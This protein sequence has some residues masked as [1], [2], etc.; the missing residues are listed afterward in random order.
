[1][2]R[3]RHKVN[4]ST[5]TW[6]LRL[7]REVSGTY[8]EE[9]SHH[10]KH[11]LTHPGRRRTRVI[12][13]S[14]GLT[15]VLAGA[16]V[17]F[18]LPSWANA[19][20]A[21]RPLAS[22][23][24][25]DTSTPT[26]TDTP[27]A[28]PTPTD[29]PT[30][31][32]TPTGTPSPV[33]LVLRPDSLTVFGGDHGGTMKPYTVDVLANDVDPAGGHLYL[34]GVTQPPHGHAAIVNNKIVVNVS[35]GTGTFVLKYSVASTS[36][37][38]GTSKLTLRI[39]PAPIRIHLGLEQKN[40]VRGVGTMMTLRFS[41]PVK[42]RAAVQAALHLYSTKSF[43]EGAWAWRD[44]TTLQ[45]R[46]F[47]RFWPGHSKITVRA[48]LGNVVMARTASGAPMV[49]LDTTASWSTGHSLIASINAKTDRM[50]VRIDNKVVRTFGVSLGKPGFTTRSGIKV[51]AEKYLIRNMT[52]QGIGVTNPND[53]FDVNAPFAVRITT[54]GEF[55]HGAPWAMY[56]I[57]K[58]NGSHGC[59]NLALW[60]AHWFYNTEIPGDVV[61]TSG[62]DRPMEYWNGEGGPWNIPWKQWVA[63]SAGPVVQWSPA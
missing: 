42:Y 28:T 16:A 41:A 15:I 11:E 32:P 46:P 35:H 53:Q 6:S 22:V 55:V 14:S 19:E 4:N 52:S 2:K 60:D 5:T 17:S 48:L 59:T 18:A 43:G 50:I 63:M 29:T 27:T 57:G 21:A 58:W 47:E 56:R 3:L 20:S 7:P 54:S 40:Q 24:P 26:P 61:V 62:T 10:G 30:A 8:P 38:T 39:Y 12:A 13:I 9:V 31:T 44:A 1:M 37:M 33:P 23:S 25:S 51:T 34:V 49:G 45:F 36:T